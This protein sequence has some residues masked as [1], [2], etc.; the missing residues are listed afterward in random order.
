MFYGKQ[1]Y[2]SQRA[3]DAEGKAAHPMSAVWESFVSQD[4][5]CVQPLRIW[6][7]QTL[8]AVSLDEK[9]AWQV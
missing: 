2:G 1:G 5:E 9:E 7:K 8:A 6:Q 3:E 4:Q